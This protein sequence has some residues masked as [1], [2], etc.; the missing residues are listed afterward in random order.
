MLGWLDSIHI[1]PS[2][3]AP[4]RETSL[5]SAVDSRYQEIIEARRV[6]AEERA[7]AA[8]AANRRAHDDATLL[9]QSQSVVEETV[10]NEI[11]HSSFAWAFSVRK[12]SKCPCVAVWRRDLNRLAFRFPICVQGGLGWVTVPNGEWEKIETSAI[13]IRKTTADLSAMSVANAELGIYPYIKYALIALALAVS[14]VVLPFLIMAVVAIAMRIIVS[15]LLF[16][17]CILAFG[18]FLGILGGK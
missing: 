5:S 3:E 13:W 6:E 7:K 9:R 1:W 10:A 2:G 4:T 18:M 15:V 17:G 12:C 11:A 14:A 8:R 16:I